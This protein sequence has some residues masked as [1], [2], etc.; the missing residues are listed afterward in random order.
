MN[1]LIDLR[2]PRVVY[3]AIHLGVT[4][5]PTQYVS[6]LLLR[7]RSPTN[8]LVCRGHVI[9]G[10]RAAPAVA[11]AQFWH[12]VGR[13]FGRTGAVTVALAMAR[14][15]VCFHLVLGDIAAR[16]SYRFTLCT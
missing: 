15:S 9:L 7:D 2:A 16:S 14:V 6:L 12:I 4:S 3:F 5:A 8:Q 1:S 10:R 11:R 13:I